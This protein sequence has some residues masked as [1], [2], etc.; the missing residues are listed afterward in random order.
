[1]LVVWVLARRTTLGNL[2]PL[3]H[4]AGG[5]AVVA[6]LLAMGGSSLGTR[7]PGCGWLRYS[8]RAIVLFQFAAAV[9]ATIGFALLE[10]EG[11]RAGKERRTLPA[12]V[13]REGLW[14]QF[15]PLWAVGLASVAVALAGFR[16]S[17]QAA[18]RFAVPRFGRPAIPGHRRDPSDRLGPGS[19]RRHGR[20]NPV[21]R[22]GPGLLRPQL[23]PVRA[24]GPARWSPRFE[25]HAS[26]RSG[27]RSGPRVCAQRPQRLDAAGRQPNDAGRLVPG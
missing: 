20:P 2:K 23:H 8:S 25:H 3:A 26:A 16:L 27:D 10:Q 19:A 21:R 24:V 22:R 4:A 7:L 11:R 12:G 6:L 5:L 1:M 18:G 15:E 14:K 9:L 17:R 13:R